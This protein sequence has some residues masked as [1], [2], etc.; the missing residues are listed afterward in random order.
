MD[1]AQNLRDL[2]NYLVELPEE[3][4][5]KMDLYGGIVEASIWWFHQHLL[6]E[7]INCCTVACVLGYAPT[8]FEIKES[9][10]SDGAF[11][12]P[13]FCKEYFLPSLVMYLSIESNKNFEF[14]FGSLYFLLISLKREN[15]IRT[16][17]GFE[18]EDGGD[19]KNSCNESCK[20]R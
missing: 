16:G 10:F 3:K 17:A 20:F 2:A 11:K 19:C 18:K 13:L 5:I 6:S 14:L 1:Y 12:Y 9:H 7:K 4:T 8:I 15:E